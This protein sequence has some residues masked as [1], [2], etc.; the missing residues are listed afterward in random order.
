V[1]ELSLLSRCQKEDLYEL[2]SSL[3]A[4]MGRPEK[5]AVDKLMAKAAH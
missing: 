3:T 4:D 5:A 1:P 2:V